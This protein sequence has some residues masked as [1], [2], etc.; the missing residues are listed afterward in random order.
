MF[1]KQLHVRILAGN[2]VVE[3]CNH[4]LHGV[5]QNVLL[6]GLQEMTVFIITT[7]KYNHI[8]IEA[9]EQM[10]SIPSFSAQG[11]M[12]TSA[13]QGSSVPALGRA[14]WQVSELGGGLNRAEHQLP[15]PPAQVGQAHSPL[16]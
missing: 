12:R 11:A 2:Q 13:L 16:C 5:T 14:P 8:M 3:Q 4:T 7:Q 10:T 9:N 15:Q 6:V 1:I